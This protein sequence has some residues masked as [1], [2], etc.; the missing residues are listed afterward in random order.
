MGFLVEELTTKYPQILAQ[1]RRGD[2]SAHEA[3][4]IVAR[5]YII[6]PSDKISGH[7]AG[8]EGLARLPSKG[9]SSSSDYSSVVTGPWG[10]HVAG[11]D[12]ALSNLIR[13]PTAAA[14]ISND[15]SRSVNQNSHVSTGPISIHGE[16]NT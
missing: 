9:Q 16:S 4:D 8:A 1:L 7:V 11:Y 6:P 5:G 3:A 2:I 12:A 13:T 15:N 14:T 10:A